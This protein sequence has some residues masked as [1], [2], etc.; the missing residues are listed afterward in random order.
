MSEYRPYAL[1]FNSKGLDLR[2]AEDQIP[3]EAFADF[4][5][6]TSDREGA[7]RTRLGRSALNTIPVAAVDLHTLA[8]LYEP[9]PIRYV[10]GDTKLFRASGTPPTYDQI[11]PGATNARLRVY[12]VD[13]LVVPTASNGHCYICSDA[14]TT[15]VIEPIWPT[16]AGDTVSDGTVTWTESNF[17]GDPM[18]TAAY[19]PGIS[20]R[21][22]LFYAN[23]TL[24]IKD[25]GTGTPSLW[26]IVPATTAATVATNAT[27]LTLVENFQSATPNSYW[28]K[29]DTG[30][31]LTLTRDD[32][33]YIGPNGDHSLKCAFSATGT[34]S[35]Q[36]NST[37]NLNL[38]NGAIAASDDDLIHIYINADVPTSITEMLLQFSIGDTNF[39][40]FYEKAIG[41]SSL[42]PGINWQT[43]THVAQ[44]PLSQQS[45]IFVSPLD[46]T[47]QTQYSPEP[48]EP[49]PNVWTNIE[50]RR[51]DFF[52][53]TAT[54]STNTWANVKAI[55]IK[56][57]VT[58]AVN[59]WFDDW[60]LEGGYGLTGSDYTWKYVYRNSATGELSNP[61]PV[62]GS[63]TTAPARQSVGVTVKT[64]Q[65]PQV[66]EIDVYREGGTTD[67]YAFSGTV[68]N[69]PTTG[70]VV[71]TDSVADIDQGD[72][73]ITTNDRPPDSDGV[74]FHLNRLWTWGGEGDAPNQLR[75]SKNVDVEAF[76]VNNYLF[77]GD[78]SEKLVRVISFDEQTL[79]AF[80]LNDVYR[81]IGTDETSFLAMK[82][83]Y[84]RGMI[85]NIFAACLTPSRIYHQHYDGIYEFPSGKKVS[86]PIDG[87]F[88]GLAINGIPPINTTYL[89][90]VRMAFYDNKL[91]VDYTSTDATENDTEMVFD[92]IYERWNKSDQAGRSLLYEKD[93]AI[94]T[95]GDPDGFV[96]EIE[97]GTTDGGNAIDFAL[98][99]GFQY[100]GLP[101]Q[102]KIWGDLALDIDTGGQD[103]TVQSIFNNGDTSDTAVTVNCSGRTQLQIPI[104]S[105]DSIVA[106]NCQLY[107]YGSAKAQ[108][109]IWKAI[110]RVLI[111]PP[112]RRTYVTD[113]SDDGKPGRKYYRTI[114][115]E[116]DTLG[117]AG[118]IVALQVD[119]TT[120]QTFDAIQTAG[121]E[122]VFLGVDTDIAGTMSRL[123]FTQV[124]D[125]ATSVF[126]LYNH[127]IQTL[128]QPD[129]PTIW[130]TEWTDNGYPYDKYWKEILLEVD[131]SGEDRTVTFQVD[132]ATVETYTIN[133]SGRTRLTHSMVDTDIVGK[134]GRIIISGGATIVWDNKYIVDNEPPDI[135]VTNTNPLDFGTEL[136][137]Q[138]KRVWV[139][140]KATSPI[141]MTIV[142][143]GV[144]RAVRTFTMPTPSSGWQK[145][146]V[147]LPPG[148]KG[149]MFDFTFESAAS[150]KIYWTQSGAAWKIIGGNNGYRDYKFEPPQL[151]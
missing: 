42:T 118:V 146:L 27:A 63:P 40:E 82:S 100:L 117:S 86:Q 90:N 33:V 128:P 76:P 8:K 61:S 49:G 11:L 39:T 111:E 29:V 53:T 144:T 102:D 119:A 28:T 96:Y 80:T 57:K 23:S 130:Q 89:D 16:G 145:V 124:D 84:G 58:G 5:N 127:N 62:S 22:Y 114:A 68:A 120:V 64:S 77:V 48:L 9:N 131:T 26:G 51:G 147:L 72:D 79:Y 94:L 95:M 43:S 50:V 38:L 31:I 91:H 106:I 149:K 66:D 59:V 44:Q 97:D 104:N 4:S 123:K 18:L 129:N 121:R 134:L 140:A 30:G 136:Y 3:I 15:G 2:D 115:L 139:S 73:I 132:N 107:I 92:T 7:V 47:P 99:T 54:D 78:A 101:D 141:T 109:S 93:T 13:D 1:I 60:N 19:S 69:D 25:K 24:M 41:P 37:L 35:I 133:A 112:R 6:L 81:I 45:D 150:F 65:D 138:I 103:V 110:Y 87:V 151:M 148:V 56:F 17:S 122:V 137:K 108:V 46:D 52:L 34:A 83:S 105:G 20:T 116:L 14:G 98:K 12:K 143:D 55:R 67:S 21:P 70:T 135:T 32:V 88:H 74:E 142:A 71:Y 125:S 36:V 85:D 113:W 75:Y 126:K 10:G